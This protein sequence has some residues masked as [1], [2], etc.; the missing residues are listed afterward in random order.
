MSQNAS[1]ICTQYMEDRCMQLTREMMSVHI[2]NICDRICENRQ[3]CKICTLEI[4][5]FECGHVVL[6]PNFFIMPL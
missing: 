2:I 1:I 5:A 3:P 4:Q 6:D